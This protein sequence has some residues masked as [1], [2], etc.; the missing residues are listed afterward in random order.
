VFLPPLS[1]DHDPPTYHLSH[2]WD[3]RHVSHQLYWLKWSLNNFLPGLALNLQISTSQAVEITDVRHQAWPKLK[4]LSPSE[5]L[6]ILELAH[7]LL[8]KV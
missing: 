3:D 4:M 2:S 6:L 7:S 5:Q 1:S 8:L